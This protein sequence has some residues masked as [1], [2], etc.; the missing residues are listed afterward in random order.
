MALETAPTPKANGFKT[1]LDTI[2]APKEAFEQL[3][4]AP[5]WGWAYI[6]TMV[7][8]VVATYLWTPALV[9][10][11]AASWGD[12][13]AQTP[14]LAQLTPEQ[15]ETQ[16]KFVLTITSFSWVFSIV[17]LPIILLIQTIVLTIFK[18][19]GRGDAGF[20]T[21]WAMATNIS[22]PSLGLGAL[23]TAIIVLIRGT[24]SFNKAADVQLAM[25]SLAMLVPGASVKLH[26]F[27][28]IV[29][30]F[31]LWGFGLTV[32]GMIVVA[33][34]SKPVA[35]MAAIIPLLI[36]AGIAALGAK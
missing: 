35:W 30:P 15:Q 13:I 33:R 3:R 32:A 36:G 27:L 8:Y 16:L 18:A 5:T 25:P 14:A 26:A 19:I 20:G 7:L 24:D 17:V 21:L 31:T 4:V 9:H 34:V 12:T 1:A 11:I 28:G 22:L 2:I 23:F 29:N 10:A 6:I